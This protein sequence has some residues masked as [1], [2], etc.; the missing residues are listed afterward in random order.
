MEHLPADEVHVWCAYPEALAAETPYA[1]AQALLTG[2]EVERLERVV[3]AQDRRIFL[4]TRALVRRVLS[5]Y[6][7]VAPEDWRFA[8]TDHGR[9]EIR[10]DGN[11]SLRFNLSNTHGLVV[12]AVFRGGE[13]GVDVEL[14]DR[15]FAH[16]ELAERYFAPTE[17]AALRA[18]LPHAQPRR[19][20]EYWTLKESYLKARGL[21]LVLPL[22]RFLFVLQPGHP[23]RFDVDP[24]LDDCGDSWR[25]TLCR[26]TADHVLALCVRTS[27]P[28]DVT[29]VLRWQPLG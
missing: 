20:C 19:F 17:V 2:D 5:R 22:D 21:G 12:C 4:A 13:I 6:E 9:P 29:V 3:S 23:P 8:I 14:V 25:F 16:L 24:A 15:T 1:A 28:R 18:L 27:P 11:P 10:S 7:S 26:P